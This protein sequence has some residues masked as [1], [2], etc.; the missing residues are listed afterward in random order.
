MVLYFS[1]AASIDSDI[2]FKNSIEAYDNRY[3]TFFDYLQPIRYKYNNGT[4]DRY[5]LGYIYQDTQEALKLANLTEQEFAGVVIL[6]EGTEN[7]HGAI[8][9]AEFVS[10]NTW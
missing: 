4:S 2:R 3:D 7:E 5:H 8:R 6:E 10:L 1:S 9:Y